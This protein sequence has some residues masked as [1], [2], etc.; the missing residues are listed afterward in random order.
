MTENSNPRFGFLFN[1]KSWE[2][3]FDRNGRQF[4]LRVWESSKHPGFWD[5]SVYGVGHNYIDETIK[6]IHPFVV[7]FAMLAQGAPED[8]DGWKELLPTPEL[9]IAQAKPQRNIHNDAVYF[10]KA[11]SYVK[12]GWAARPLERLKTFETGCPHKLELLATIP[13]G[14]SAESQMHRKFKSLRYRG[15]WFHYD[16]KLKEFIDSLP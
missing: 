9:P 11:A 15:E 5:Y 7:G 16:G 6:P 13:G 14:V 12:I 4:L 1:G 2:C 3:I 8:R 10:I